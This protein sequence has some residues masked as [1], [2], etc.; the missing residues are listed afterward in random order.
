ML[1][2]HHCRRCGRLSCDSCAPKDNTRPI[3]EVSYRRSGTPKAPE[4]RSF[5]TREHPWLFQ[6]VTREHTPSWCGFRKLA[7]SNSG[8]V[9]RVSKYRLRHCIPRCLGK[10]FETID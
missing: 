2:R 6:L 3:V 1:R 9:C 4:S 10:L 5:T 8:E 7:V